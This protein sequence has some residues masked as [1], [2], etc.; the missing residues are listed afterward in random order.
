MPSTLVLPS[1]FS[2]TMKDGR[3]TDA[4]WWRHDGSCFW[5]GILVPPV[6]LLRKLRRQVLLPLWVSYFHIYD[7]DS[8]S[9]CLLPFIH[10]Q[11]PHRSIYLVSSLSSF[12]VV[13]ALLCD[14]HLNSILAPLS[15]PHLIGDFTAT[16]SLT[17]FPTPSIH[18]LFHRN[19]SSLNRNLH[20]HFFA[21]PTRL[22]QT[23]IPWP[24]SFF[25]VRLT[26][27]LSSQP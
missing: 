14:D 1:V 15:C 13:C 18:K 10:C 25:C 11:Q 20:W 6:P 2:C 5:P 23:L 22:C 26:L 27:F 12:L 19:P 3:K 4:S 21:N 9:L 17:A 16:V 8:K 24:P 7:S